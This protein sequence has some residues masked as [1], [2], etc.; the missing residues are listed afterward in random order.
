MPRGGK[1]EGTGRP[2][3]GEARRQ[4]A[5]RLSDEEYHVLVRSG[6]SVRVGTHGY[7]TATDALRRLIE[8]ERK[9]LDRLG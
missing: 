3:T 1:R 4:R 6:R 8:R 9:R 2:P 7:E 5:F